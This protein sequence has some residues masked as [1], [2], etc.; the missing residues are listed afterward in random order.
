MKERFNIFVIEKSNNKH[1]QLEVNVISIKELD[2]IIAN[3]FKN[4][5]ELSSYIITKAKELENNKNGRYYKVYQPYP[6]IKII[7]STKDKPVK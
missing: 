5:G 1:V 7:T 6:S 2:N 3:N 4:Y